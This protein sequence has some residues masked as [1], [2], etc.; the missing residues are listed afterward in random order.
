M[1]AVEFYFAVNNLDVVPKLLVEALLLH[2]CIQ[3]RRLRVENV[4]LISVVSMFA[5]AVVV[6]EGIAVILQRR[7]IILNIT[8]KLLIFETQPLLLD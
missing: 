7:K 1:E 3:N 2:K 6:F 4:H 5:L 8:H